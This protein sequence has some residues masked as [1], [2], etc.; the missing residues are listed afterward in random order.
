MF[1]ILNRYIFR[2]M[3]APFFL[4][5]V[6]FMFVFLMT[7]LLDITNY[8]VNYKVSI[9]SFLMLLLFSIP[10]SLQFV[11]PISVM[12]AVLL[13][14][15]RMSGDNEIIALKSAGVGIYSFLPPVLLFC[16]IGCLI[17]GVMA[18]YG[19]P[20]GRTSMK[21]LAKDIAASSL[22]IGLKERTFND[23]FENVVMYVNK[24]DAKSNRLRDVF[25]EDERNE[26]VI[27]TVVASTGELQS[28]P[29]KLLFRLRL[30]NGTINQVNIE[31]QSVNTVS[32]ET[33]DIN[34]NIA[35][36]F[37]GNKTES[38]HRLEMSLTEIRHYLKTNPQKDVG[39]YKT[40]MD[41]H[42]KFSISFACVVLGI[43][44]VPLGFQ[45]S[46]T[47]RS[48]GLVIGLASFM[49]YYILLTAG[50]GFGGSGS[51]PPVLAMWFPNVVFG[52]LGIYLLYRVGRE[53]PLMLDRITDFY[54]WFIGKISK[55]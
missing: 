8:I 55:Q 6:F 26:Q 20:W 23:S 22:E 18:I 5:I 15:L 10:F 33:Y 42:K 17:T 46:I 21:K 31:D 1:S 51:F 11:I 41:Y 54:A 53:R 38:K 39:Y 50:W 12:I 24:I 27:T 45:A 35:K 47:R 13:T 48:Y 4:N 36:A 32:F 52:G 30:F 44:A 16:L 3:V 37:D 49:V 29:K 14:L 40:L 2:E 28:E 9:L 7:T 34:L 25:I 43:F 19:T